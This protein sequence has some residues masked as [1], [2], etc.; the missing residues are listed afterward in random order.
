MTI[1]SQKAMRIKAMLVDPER[2]HADI[3]REVGVS[4]EYVRQVAERKPE[5]THIFKADFLK[6][7]RESKGWTIRALADKIGVNCSEITRWETGVHVPRQSRI[8]QLAKAFGI[9]EYQFTVSEESYEP[10]TAGSGGK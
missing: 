10:A 4:R 3:A 7:L 8:K 5:R 9:R 1:R 2:S 6:R